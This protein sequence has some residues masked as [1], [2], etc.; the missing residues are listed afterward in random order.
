MS[1]DDFKKLNNKYSNVLELC[2]HYYLEEAGRK[3]YNVI[4]WNSF[5]NGF[6]MWV[7]MMNFG[8]FQQGM[9]NGI[10]NLRRQHGV[11]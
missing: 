8:H 4:D 5:N 2:Y 1:N 3:K 6:T 10:T 9:T 11:I 7:S